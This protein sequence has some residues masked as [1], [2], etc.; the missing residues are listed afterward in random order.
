MADQ[1]IKYSKEQLIELASQI[2]ATERRLQ[3]THQELGG[4]VNGLVA[5]WDG[6]AREA[7][8]ATQ[9]KWDQAQQKLMVTLETIA[10]VVEDGAISMAEMD[11]MNSRSWA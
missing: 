5:E 3:E 9:A 6:G 7:Y 2:R 4:Y 8:Q 1:G 11:M 10:K